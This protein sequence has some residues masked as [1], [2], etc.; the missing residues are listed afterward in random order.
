MKARVWLQRRWRRKRVARSCSLGYPANT[1]SN[2]WK[3][4]QSYLQHE[5][6]RGLLTQCDFSPSA[7]SGLGEEKRGEG[8]R[9]GSR[10]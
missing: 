3:S 7:W 4:A 1:S 5:V 10:P 9:D 8:W 6:T 2:A